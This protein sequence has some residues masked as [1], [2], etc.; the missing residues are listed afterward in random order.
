MQ[1]HT[2]KRQSRHAMKVQVKRQADL[3]SV[4]CS[5]SEYPEKCRLFVER[6]EQAA[7]NVDR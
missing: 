2:K 1:K 4:M 7:L 6:L 5:D 3:F